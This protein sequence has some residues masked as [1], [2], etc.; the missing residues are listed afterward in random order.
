MPLRKGKSHKVISSNVKELVHDR[1][2]DGTIGNSHPTS[3]KKAV[4]QAVAIAM[5]TAGVGRRQSRRTTLPI[6]TGSA[7]VHRLARVRYSAVAGLR[8]G[9]VRIRVEAL[10]LTPRGSI[11]FTGHAG[12]D[13]HK[14]D[15][16][17]PRYQAQ[18][19]P[20]KLHLRPRSVAVTLAFWHFPA[21][22][23][24]VQNCAISRNAR[25]TG[26]GAGVNRFTPPPQPWCRLPV[27]RCIGI[28]LIAP[29]EVT[30]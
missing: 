13:E 30:T 8:D 14:E 7:P 20:A 24:R 28:A 17:H 12:Q 3:S 1:E 22:P 15:A 26:V 4:K 11:L 9:H 10:F 18:H 25:T 5:F 19:N 29:T 21:M 23:G 2:T 16:Q 6:V 27:A